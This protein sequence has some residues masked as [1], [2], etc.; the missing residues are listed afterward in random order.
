ML[1]SLVLEE[2]AEIDYNILQSIND[3]RIINKHGELLKKLESFQA[4]Y[5]EEKLLSDNKFRNGEEYQEAFTEFKKYLALSKI[6]GKKMSMM[7]EKVDEVWHQFILFTPQ[8]HKFCEEVL[9]GYFH[10]I[11][12]TSLTPLDPKGREN[13]IES[14]RKIFGEI[15]EIWGLK[16]K[17][18]AICDDGCSPSGMC[19]PCNNLCGYCKE[20]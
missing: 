12:K 6:V 10:H 14:Y 5:L 2:S 18:G 11:P 15:P 8:Y 4:P 13:F 20:S 19:R 17:A 9:E 3:S 7:S 1:D 16:N